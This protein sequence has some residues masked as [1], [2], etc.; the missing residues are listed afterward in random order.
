MSFSEEITQLVVIIVV[1]LL[2]YM[3]INVWTK[4]GGKLTLPSM[5]GGGSGGEGNAGGA[6]GVGAVD[7][8]VAD[9]TDYPRSGNAADRH[10]DRFNLT[11]PTAEAAAKVLK[12]MLHDDE[13]FKER[14]K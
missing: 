10:G 7:D 1:L 8:D 14:S 13:E 6:G 3:G 2:A 4:R 12:R 5:G 9:T 11:G